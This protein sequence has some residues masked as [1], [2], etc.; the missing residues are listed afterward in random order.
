MAGLGF[1]L[2]LGNTGAFV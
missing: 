2:A 1:V